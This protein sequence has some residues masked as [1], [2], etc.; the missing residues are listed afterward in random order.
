MKEDREISMIKRFFMEKKLVFWLCLVIWLIG[1]IYLVIPSASLPPLPNSYKSNE[2]GDTVEIY[3]VSAYYTSL[4]RQEILDFYLVNF[5]K[6]RFF[7]LPFPAILLNHP[8]EYV[9]TAIRDTV[10]STFLYELVHPFRDSLIINGWSPEEDRR[11]KEN[12]KLIHIGKKV[13]K[14]KITLRYLPSN[15]ILRISIFTISLWLFFYLWQRLWLIVGKTWKAL[16]K[17]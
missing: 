3:G 8:P 2:P 7:N 11:Y 16:R 4:S 6:S 13:F 15:I 17:R 1:L 14:Q 9:S 10:N 5:N 12:E